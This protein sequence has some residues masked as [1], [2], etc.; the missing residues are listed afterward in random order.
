MNGNSPVVEL[1]SREYSTVL[2]KRIPFEVS[3]QFRNLA[4]IFS[5]GMSYYYV[6]NLKDLQMEY[7]SPEV[8]RITGIPPEEVTIEKL[9]DT[10]LQEEVE[11]LVKKEQVVRDFFSRISP[12]D[13]TCYKLIYSYRMMDSRQVHRHILHQA[14]PLSVSE[15]GCVQHVLSIHSDVSH[16]KLPRNPRISFVHLRDQKKS[17]Y[18]LSTDTGKFL[19]NSIE[20]KTQQLSQVLSSREKEVLQLLAKGHKAS[21]IAEMLHL[22]FNTIRTHRKNMLKKTEC[23]NT[24]ELVARGLMEGIIL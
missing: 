10:A 1:W 18:N 3:E 19:P 21:Q 23:A 22:S 7:V 17:Y 12:E 20:V 4:A 2:K 6:M 13:L 11:T 14:I 5:P 9:V 16:L 24:A 15:E 8:E